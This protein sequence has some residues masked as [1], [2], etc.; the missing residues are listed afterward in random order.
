MA[1][2]NTQEVGI[3]HL[4]VALELFS[5]YK[6]RSY[7]RDVI[8]EEDVVR[9]SKDPTK[10]RDRLT[11]RSGVGSQLPNRGDSNKA[12]LG[13][14]TRCPTG[15]LIQVEP[16]RSQLMMFVSWPGESHEN[17]DVEERDHGLE[18]VVQR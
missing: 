13:Q 10:S 14:W 12:A 1:K 3:G 5:G 7:E 16:S 17:V 15:L 4:A 11:R 8:R 9:E 18:V 6:L 2:G